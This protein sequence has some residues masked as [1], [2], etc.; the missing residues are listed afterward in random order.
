MATNQLYYDLLNKRDMEYLETC[1]YVRSHIFLT[2]VRDFRFILQGARSEN[3]RLARRMTADGAEA[4]K[5]E[6]W[7]V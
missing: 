6:T 7:L 5:I 2:L 3:P 4:S 1:E